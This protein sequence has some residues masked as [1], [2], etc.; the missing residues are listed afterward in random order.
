M[1]ESKSLCLLVSLYIQALL[2]DG[3][4]RAEDEEGS[5]EAAP[6]AKPQPSLLLLE[7]ASFA[8]A[9]AGLAHDAALLYKEIMCGLQSGKAD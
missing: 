4:L 1:K 7:C 8:L 6:A 5:P 3:L 9:H 2:R